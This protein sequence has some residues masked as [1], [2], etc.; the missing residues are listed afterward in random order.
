MA[1]KLLS[2]AVGAASIASAASSAGISSGN[3]QPSF[4]S[5]MT[6]RR[7]QAEGKSYSYLDDLTGYS[8]QYATCLRVKIPQENDDDA[9]DGN[10]NFYAGAYRAQYAVYATFHVC[11][12]GS[13]SDQCYDCDFGTEYAAPVEQFLETSLEHWE[14]YCG[15][16]QNACRRRLEEDAGGND[17]DCNACSSSCEN[18]QAGDDD[19]T[20]YVDCQA[21]FQ[22]EDGLQLYYG[23]QC[24]NGELAIG[25]FYDDEC[26]IKAK[27]DSPNFNYYKFS[28]V[29]D[30]CVDCSDNYGADTCDDL[31]ADGSYHCVNGRDQLGQDNEMSVCSA[32]KKA[33]TNVDYSNVKKRSSGADKFL[34]VFFGLLLVSLVGG[35]FFLTFTYYIRHRGDKAQP[36]LNSEDVH[37]EEAGG[38]VGQATSPTATLT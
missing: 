25:V 12:D 33:L 37:E 36:I 11:G 18:Y 2:F 20:N 5:A 1:M 3:N 6:S 32:V 19:E 35:F 28:T 29:Q 38:A 4:R 23:P 13:G 10:V 17:I 27:Y 7:L 26:T 8:L 15:A 31:Y 30:G 16:C 34:K 9:V 21:A 14:N 24:E 22:D